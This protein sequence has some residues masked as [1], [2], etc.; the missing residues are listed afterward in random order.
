M[1]WFFGCMMRNNHMLLA[2]WFDGGSV[3]FVVQCKQSKCLRWLTQVVWWC[4]WQTKTMMEMVWLGEGAGGANVVLFW[5][6]RQMKF[7]GGCKWSDGSQFAVVLREYCERS[8]QRAAAGALKNRHFQKMGHVT[9]LTTALV[10]LEHVRS[11]SVQKPK[12]WKHKLYLKCRRTCNAG[13][14]ETVRLECK[15]PH[16]DVNMK[17]DEI[18]LLLMFTFTML[19]N[20]AHS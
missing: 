8:E 11:E 4:S 7:L 14:N 19:S 10:A 17:R 9:S 20:T 2:G 18:A 15:S 16:I 3:T 5:L 1:P 12:F 6:Q 13:C